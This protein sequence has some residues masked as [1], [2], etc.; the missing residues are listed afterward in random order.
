MTCIIIAAVVTCTGLAAP[1]PPAEAIRILT[2]SVRPFDP[3]SVVVV[4]PPTPPAMIVSEPPPLFPEFP[5]ARRLDGTLVDQ[6][7]MV[8]GPPIAA[9]PFGLSPQRSLRNR[10]PRSGVVRNS[11]PVAPPPSVRQAPRGR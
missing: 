1:P 4:V 10:P 11:S 5:P 8:Y 6:P 9:V 2:A 3:Q 7:P